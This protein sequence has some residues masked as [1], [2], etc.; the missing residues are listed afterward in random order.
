MV[1]KGQSAMEFVIIVGAVLFFFFI[2]LFSIQI[3]TGN[4][5]KEQ[6]LLAMKDLALNL[7]NEIDL[8]GKASVGYKREF[9]IQEKLLNGV[10]YSLILNGDVVYINSS[11]DEGL[12]YPVLN[13]TGSV[14]KGSNVIRK[15]TDAIYLNR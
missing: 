7:Q 11:Y 8:A 15:E 2:F 1:R 13:V 4:K 12:A 5:V 3:N 6:R 10:D 9:V 14:V